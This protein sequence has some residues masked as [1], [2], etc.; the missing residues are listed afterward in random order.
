[1]AEGRNT[2][3]HITHIFG[4]L[5]D[6]SRL[7]SLRG[8]WGWILTLGIVYLTTGFIALGSIVSAT[9]ASVFIVGI[10]MLIA[11]IA[12]VINSFQIKAWGK[13][14]FWLLLGALYIVAGLVTFENPLLAAA[15]L[16]LILGVVLIAS[17][18]M[19]IILAL[20]MQQENPWIW[21]AVSG[22]LTL[23]VGLVILARWPVSSLFVLGLFLGID[24]VFAGVGWIGL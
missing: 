3:A 14:L 21:I 9:A 17:G 22:L 2:M 5:D 10:M 11:G 8:K 24:L 7:E 6:G 23:I 15:T 20:S 13:F 4:S 19:R 16:T 12:E 1:M 18:I